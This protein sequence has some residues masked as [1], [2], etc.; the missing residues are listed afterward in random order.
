MRCTLLATLAFACQV[1]IAAPFRRSGTLSTIRQHYGCPVSTVAWYG[2]SSAH[3]DVGDGG[4]CHSR[5]RPLFQTPCWV[6]TSTDR[7]QNGA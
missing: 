2:Y 3:Y 6:V 7:P 4:G 1:A 5:R